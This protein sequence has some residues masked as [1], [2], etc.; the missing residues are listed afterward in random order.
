MKIVKENQGQKGTNVSGWRLMDAYHTKGFIRRHACT[1]TATCER[2]DGI[3]VWPSGK[4]TLRSR[5]N[6]GL[7]NIKGVFLEKCYLKSYIKY[8]QPETRFPR[9][10]NLDFYIAGERMGSLFIQ[11]CNYSDALHQKEK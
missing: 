9:N 6:D 7:L 4:W 1:H 2:A 8:C 10:I 5:R 3:H 11:F